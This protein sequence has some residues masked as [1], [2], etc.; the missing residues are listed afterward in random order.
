MNSFEL[1]KI[2]GAILAT[3]VFVMGVGFIA[4]EIYAPIENRGA[5]FELPEPEEVAEGEAPDAPQVPSIAARLQTASAEAGEGIVV[6]CQGC[7]DLTEA[8]TNR[9]GPGLYEVVGRPIAA[10]EGFSYSQALMEL[11]AA[12]GEWSYDELDHFLESPSGFAP[13]TTMGFAGLPNPQE[14]ADLIAYLRELSA[15][16]QPLPEAPA[17]EEAAAPAEGEEAAAAEE[18]AADAGPD[19]DTLIANADIGL[20]ESIAP[21]C[22]GCHDITEANTNRVGPGLYGIIGHDI[23]SHEDFNYSAAL[24]ELGDAGEVWDFANLDAFLTSPSSFAPGTTMGFAGLPNDEERIALIAWLREQSS[25][26]VPLAAASED[27]APAADEAAA[28]QA[29]A[30]EEEAAA[31]EAPVEE[32][33]PVE[34]APAEEEA[35]PA[36]E[37]APVEEDA[38]P[39][40]EEPA[41]AAPAEE[42]AAPAAEEEP[43]V[44]DEPVAEDNAAAAEP[45]AEEE[46]PAAVAEED[47][48]AGSGY[49]TAEQV[50]T[51]QTT[52]QQRCATCHGTDL[53]NSIAGYPNAG[54]FYSYASSAMPADAPGSLRPQ[55]YAD[56]IAYL[57]NENGHPIGTEVLP[58]DQAI[59]GEIDPD[60]FK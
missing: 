48:A 10:H 35:A 44:E 1:N 18:P 20:G 58:P 26:P 40:E 28:E 5:G 21:R 54:L 42:P 33:A 45:E 49:M 37:A 52:Y 43:A 14:R 25:D 60:E 38:A 53:I 32:A 4:E 9:V 31:E 3:L 19:Y 46:A 30:A 55:Q 36:E 2:F 24:T 12:D 6:R 22:Q 29:P 27:E 15:D 11:A 51:G 23:A 16:P 13:G 39:A 7:H 34:A 47:A 17:E 56:I 50:A 41:E 8:N 57:L 59:M